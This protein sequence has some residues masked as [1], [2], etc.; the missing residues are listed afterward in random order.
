[1]KILAIDAGRGS[2]SPVSQTL[3]AAASAAENAGA[4]VEWLSL[5]NY[6]IH[7]CVGCML[8]ALGDGCKVDDDLQ[9]L[10]AHIAEADGVM[11]G[12]PPERESAARAFSALLARLR[13]WF[14]E[15]NQPHLPGLG[16]A[17]VRPSPVARAAKRA[18]IITSATKG[19]SI[20]AFFGNSG[21]RIRNLRQALAACNIKAVGSMSV[22]R[23]SK[24][25]GKRSELSYQQWDQAA[26][27]GRL[28]A[29]KL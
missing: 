9:E 1:V 2:G 4:Q 16:P 22:R 19:G 12:A 18:I 20:G 26:S 15:N 11:F 21:G 3:A 27:L 23:N 5:R 7:D 28:L 24:S 29:G 13:T 25:R 14:E 17:D 8:C 6:R 10:S